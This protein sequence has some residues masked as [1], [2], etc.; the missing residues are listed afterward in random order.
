MIEKKHDGA[1]NGWHVKKE[2]SIS[3][4]ITTG[5]IAAGLV[6]QFVMMQAKNDQQDMRLEN[7]ESAVRE[8]SSTLR[9]LQT[10]MAR[11]DERTLAIAQAIDRLERAQD[12]GQ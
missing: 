2:V 11:I 9:G 8:N 6:T 10:T 1:I 7:V 4:I 12:D 5:M 3:H